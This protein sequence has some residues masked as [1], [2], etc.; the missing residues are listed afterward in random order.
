VL[1]SPY[2]SMTDMAR[3]LVGPLAPLLVPDRFDSQ[4]R[5]PSV[6]LPVV[7]IHGTADDLVPFEMGQAL[8]RRFP[9]ARLVPIAGAGHVDIPGLAELIVREVAAVAADR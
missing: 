8:A 9:R 2:T 3:P 6:E 7:V 4:A 1:V 5:A